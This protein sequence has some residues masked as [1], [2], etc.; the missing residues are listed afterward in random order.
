VG[1]SRRGCGTVWE[2]VWSSLGVGVGQSGGV[3]G[4]VREWLLH[5][6]GVYMG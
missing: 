6:L 5:G 4:A 3:F 2:C 1:Q